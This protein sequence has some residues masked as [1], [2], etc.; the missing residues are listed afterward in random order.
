MRLLFCCGVLCLGACGPSLLRPMRPEPPPAD[1]AGGGSVSGTVLGKPFT[2]T[3][4]E[5]YSAD[6]TAS[7]IIHDGAG[8]RCP[9]SVNANTSDILFTVD[10]SRRKDLRRRVFQLRRVRWSLQ[11]KRRDIGLWIG[12]H[13]RRQHELGEWQLL[14]QVQLG[15]GHRYIRCS[16][17]RGRSEQ[18]P[19][20][21]QVAGR[22]STR[23]R[24]A[25]R[26]PTLAATATSSGPRA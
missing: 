11:P 21:L 2:M 8:Q 18:R 12:H 22:G 26:P 6:G 4:A 20:N 3:D 13:Y 17:V 24:G 10:R 19:S 7:F 15:H 14:G 1:A 16:D 9:D 23:R 25:L 5:Y